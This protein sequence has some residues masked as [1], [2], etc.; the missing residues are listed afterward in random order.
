ML[1]AQR[2]QRII[3]ALGRKGTVRTEDLAALLGVSHETVRRDLAILERRA[4]LVRVHGGATSAPSGTGEELSYL[5]RST[6]QSEAKAVIGELAAQLLR[7][8]QTVVIDVGTTAVHVA[9]AVPPSFRGV[10]ATCSLLVAAELAG[11]PGVE[12]L[13]AGGRVR[14]GDLAVSNAHTLGFFQD[15][16]ADVAF[17]GSGGVDAEAGLTDY[18]LDEVA[19][20]RVILANTART[21]V[22][23]DSSKHGRV[24]AYRV[25]ALDDL[26]GLITDGEPPSALASA[27]VRAGAEVINP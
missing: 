7:P 10:V 26:S 27:L 15:L 4:L 21:Y 11:R 14:Q 16:R 8:G 12:V 20:K 6:S 23:A 5:E 25:C 18:F 17:L 13:V 24:A 3:E 9:R 1:P 22:L 19:T 2:H